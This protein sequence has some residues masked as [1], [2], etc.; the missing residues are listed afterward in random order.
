MTAHS[1]ATPRSQLQCMID[2][3]HCYAP[4][5]CGD[6][7]LCIHHQIAQAALL[8]ERVAST[9]R[10]KSL[11][12]HW[13]PARCLHLADATGIEALCELLNSLPVLIVNPPKGWTP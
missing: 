2:T 4:N 10:P 3:M 11:S 13:T 7:H 6:K 12:G 1:S 9:S 5:P 8:S